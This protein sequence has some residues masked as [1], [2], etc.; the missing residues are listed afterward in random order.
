M[1][2]SGCS[3]NFYKILGIAVDY[4]LCEKNKK[5]T[6]K[7]QWKCA[8]TAIS[9]IFPVF[10]AGKFFLRN[11]TR[12]YF[13]HCY[14]AFLNK[15]SVKT[16][17]EISRKHKKNGFSGIFPAFWKSGSGIFGR[18]KLFFEN[19]ARSHFRHCHFAS[20]CKISWKNI[21]YS[22]RNSRNPVFFRRKSAVPAIFRKF[23]LQKSV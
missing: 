17:D 13:G 5:Y 2:K 18:N 14:Y 9:G 23:R 6:E 7:V 11:R 8:K 4:I 16:N 19:W 20:V 15:E 1:P 21:K 3:G 12:P 10:S 22:S